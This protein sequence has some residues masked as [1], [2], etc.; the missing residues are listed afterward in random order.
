M[1]VNLILLLFYSIFQAHLNKLFI[2]RYISHAYLTAHNWW[3]GK[4]RFL[5]VDAIEFKGT[6]QLVYLS[7]DTLKLQFLWICK[8]WDNFVPK[9]YFVNNCLIQYQI[10]KSICTYVTQGSV[11]ICQTPYFVLTWSISM[12]LKCRLPFPILHFFL[13]VKTLGLNQRWG[14]KKML[15]KRVKP[16]TFFFTYATVGSNISF[17]RKF[18]SF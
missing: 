11:I 4:S 16:V 7:N 14:S 1:V 18:H 12:Q 2:S 13:T 17:N 8:I 15:L 9:W 6:K 10:L 5:H 3:K